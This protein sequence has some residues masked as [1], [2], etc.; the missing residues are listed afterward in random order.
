MDLYYERK[1]LKLIRSKNLGFTMIET[2]IAL[3][4]SSFIMLALTQVY[5]SLITYIGKAQDMA[6]ANTRLVMVCNL[7]ERDLT[8]ACM[9]QLHQEIV[10]DKGKDLGK[11]KS[12]ADKKEEEEKE[13]TVEAST[14]EGKTKQQEEKQKER[15]KKYFFTEI[16]DA[17]LH[18]FRGNKA[19]LLKSCN[20]ITTSALDTYSEASSR[21]VRVRYELRKNKKAERPEYSL[22][23]KQTTDIHNI[24]M[25]ISEVDPAA[26]LRAAPITEHEVLSNIKNFFIEFSMKKPIEKKEEESEA[27]AKKEPELEEIKAFNWGESKKTVGEMPQRAHIMMELWHVNDQATDSFDFELLMR[28]EGDVAKILEQPKKRSPFGVPGSM[29]PSRKPAGETGAGGKE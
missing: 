21:F 11:E 25:K 8:A 13:K 19:E 17:E 12:E 18:K 29:M 14:E 22:W 15:R 28:T 3:A 26:A 10:P 16:D 4:L 5:R 7:I 23:R 20:F 24:K 1:S 27:S 9:P 2:L 6:Q